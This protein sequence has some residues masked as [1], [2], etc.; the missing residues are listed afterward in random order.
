MKWY[1]TNHKSPLTSLHDAVL[2]GL[3]PDGSLYLPTEIPSFS[4]N[5]IEHL[6]SMSI[7]DIAFEV[8]RQFTKQEIT[9]AAL[10]EIIDCAITFD[11][12]LAKIEDEVYSLELF[13][14]PTLAFKD[15]GARFMARI[16]ANF[17]QNLD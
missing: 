17:V 13:H 2:Q 12:P 4:L 10:E 5:F 11:A 16:M 8:A 1:S 7:Q 9:K 3:A 15:F 14:G 6:H